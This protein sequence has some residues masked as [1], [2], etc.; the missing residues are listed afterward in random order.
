MSLP[1]IK[2]IDSARHMDGESWEVG[3]EAGY[4]TG[5][6]ITEI[7]DM[8]SEFDDSINVSYDIYANGKL[9]KTLVNMPVQV[10]YEIEGESNE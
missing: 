2:R 10:T 1:K 5:L 7:K 3:Q 9:Y 6:I 4:Q 8:T